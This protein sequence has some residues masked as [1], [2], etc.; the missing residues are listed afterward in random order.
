MASSLFSEMKM[1]GTLFFIVFVI[2]HTDRTVN[3]F[4]CFSVGKS[5]SSV[6]GLYS[7]E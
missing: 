1:D 4:S 3:H 6:S 5:E 7:V 2:C